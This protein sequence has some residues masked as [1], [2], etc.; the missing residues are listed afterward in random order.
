[1][2]QKYRNQPIDVLLN[3]AGISGGRES[4][5]FGNLQYEV[6]NQVMAVNVLGPLKMV[7][8]LPGPSGPLCQKQEKGAEDEYASSWPRWAPRCAQGRITL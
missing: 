7:E 6:Y 5:Q 3:N 8:K 2:A 1:M 4:Q